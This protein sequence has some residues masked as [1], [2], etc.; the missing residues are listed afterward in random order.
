M[1]EV[2][3]GEINNPDKKTADEFEDFKLFLKK[4][5]IQNDVLRKLIEKNGID[6]AI[7]K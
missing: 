3:K 6:S 1:S 2:K 4:K 5:K 7:N